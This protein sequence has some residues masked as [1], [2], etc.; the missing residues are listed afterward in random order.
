[1][2]DWKTLPLTLYYYGTCPY[3]WWW[4]RR[5]AAEH[6]VPVVV[7]FYHRIADDRANSWTTSN[8]TFARQIDWLANT[9]RSSRWPRPSGG[10]NAATTPGPA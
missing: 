5:A 10:S 2:P 3:R 7:L 4:M 8:R 6:R 9:S 1:M